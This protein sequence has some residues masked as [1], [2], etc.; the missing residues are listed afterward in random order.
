MWSAGCILGELLAHKPLLPGR[1]E[2][3]QL[4]LIIDLFGTPND[5]IWPEF[6]KLPVVQ[7]LILIKLAEQCWWKHSSSC[8]FCSA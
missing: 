3:H 7:V 6:S 2:I 8:S 5:N 4:E 1:S